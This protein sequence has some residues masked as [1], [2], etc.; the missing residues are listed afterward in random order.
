MGTA[1]DASEKAEWELVLAEVTPAGRRTHLINLL[2]A[3]PASATKAYTVGDFEALTTDKDVHDT[4]EDVGG[5]RLGDVRFLCSLWKKR[6]EVSDVSS[7]PVLLT[8]MRARVA[9]AQGRGDSAARMAAVVDKA[10][11]DA[12]DTQADIEGKS[13]FA[14]ALLRLRVDSSKLGVVSRQGVLEE[15][16]LEFGEKGV[17]IATSE[18]KRHLG[19]EEEFRE[20]WRDLK[21]NCREFKRHGLVIRLQEIQD[22]MESM[23][24]WHIQAEYF[25]L[26]MKKFRGRLAKAE[27]S[28]LYIQAVRKVGGALPSTAAVPTGAAA[29]GAQSMLRSPALTGGAEPAM[30]SVLAAA[31]A[32]VEQLTIMMKDL[33]K[34]VKGRPAAPPAPE[35]APEPKESKSAAKRRKA[36]ERKQGAAAPE[37]KDGEAE[38]EAP[39]E[40][41]AEDKPGGMSYW[42]RLKSKMDFVPTDDWA[43]M[44]ASERGA[45]FRRRE[46]AAKAAAKAADDAAHKEHARDGGGKRGAKRPRK[47]DPVAEEGE[48]EAAPN[49]KN[50][51]AS[52][53]GAAEGVSPG[54]TQ[55]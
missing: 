3:A 33:G 15:A 37:A 54:V 43:R 20:Y 51:A 39:A 27:D 40:A 28:G 23:R 25:R 29:P 49:A 45:L 26:Y 14:Y 2:C 50:A 22:D 11:S 34:E 8:T 13:N 1:L 47:L 44:T 12:M 19:S 21:D 55:E 9:A 41:P 42:Q 16:E 36:L 35:P 24:D 5:M 53:A 52:A 38:E 30:A 46:E 17:E 31:Q 7:Q 10:V 4:F 48:G 32:C 18:W 6:D